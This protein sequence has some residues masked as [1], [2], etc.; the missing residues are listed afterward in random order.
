MAG[1]PPMVTPAEHIDATAAPRSRRFLTGLRDHAYIL[2]GAALALGAFLWMVTYG[3]GALLGRETFGQFY[4]GQAKALL[5]G[6]WDVQQQYIGD[7]AFVRDGKFYGYF[8]FVPAVLRIPAAVLMP[9][10]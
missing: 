10:R 9:S 5:A 8:G 7:E 6:R 4:D 1:G 2:P 3:T